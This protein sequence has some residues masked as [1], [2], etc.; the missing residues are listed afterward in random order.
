MSRPSDLADLGGRRVLVTGAGDV[1]AAIAMAFARHG[2]GLVAIVD[3]DERRATTVAK[4]V[5]SM[6]ARGLPLVT[7]LTDTEAVEALPR[8]VEAAGESIDVLVNNAGIPPDFFEVGRGL[9]P[10]S[11]SD[12]TDWAPL[13]DLNLGAVLRMTRAFVGPMLEQRWGRILTIVSDSARTGDRNMAVYAAAKGGAS[14]FMRSIASEVGLSNVTANCISLGTIWRSVEP[15][16]ERMEKV[17]RRDYP[18]GRYGTPEDV[19]SMAVF[20]ASDAANWIT[21]QVYGVNG[22]Y[23]YGL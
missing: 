2:A 8:A 1:G 9:S 5:E 21:G 12:P 7:D 11:D 3:L 18:L 19:A 4:R 17:A 13:L 23:S 20:L 6:G 10:F 22:G 16:D 14:A 15:P